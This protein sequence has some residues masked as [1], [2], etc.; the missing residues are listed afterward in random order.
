MMRRPILVLILVCIGISTV[1]RG[2]LSVSVG[3]KLQN[4]LAFA[5]FL[6]QGNNNGVELGWASAEGRII[7]P[8]LSLS[9]SVAL[10]SALIRLRLPLPSPVSPFMILGG[11]ST[12]A[13][14]RGRFEGSET[15]FQIAQEGIQAGA[16]LEYTKSPVSVFGNVLYTFVPLKPVSLEI[17]G[18]LHTLTVPV[19][20]ARRWGWGIGVRYTFSLDALLAPLSSF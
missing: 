10:Y 6:V 17:N 16:G 7:Q 14:V 20:G 5:V 19:P 4:E 2:Q 3:G 18:G 8:N 13:F 15:S 12:R 1:A 9:T 11:L